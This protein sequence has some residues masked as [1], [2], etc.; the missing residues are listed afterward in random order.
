M[1]Y[2]L[3]FVINDVDIQH[4]SNI[5]L[6]IHVLFETPVYSCEWVKAFF[7]S[8]QT[9]FFYVA[10]VLLCSP[11]ISFRRDLGV[12]SLKR[13]SL[14]SHSELQGCMSLGSTRLV[15]AARHVAIELM[16]EH[17]FAT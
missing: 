11:S 15:P 5:H 6:Q 3:H 17:A 7:Q 9:T 14:N 12:L 13:A 4:A 16:Q 8:F 2:I 10:G 1:L